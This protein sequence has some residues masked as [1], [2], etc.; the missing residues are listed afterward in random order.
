MTTVHGNATCTFGSINSQ[1]P[2]PTTTYGLHVNTAKTARCPGNATAW[3]LCYYTT[4]SK[5]IV[6]LGVYRPSSASSYSLVPGSS[7][8]YTVPS[9]LT[10]TSPIPPCI[11]TSIPLSQ[12]FV[13]QMGDVIAACLKSSTS[14]ERLN[15]VGTSA[16]S[17]TPQIQV[18]SANTCESLQSA[19]PRTITL[20]TQEG[21]SGSFSLMLQVSLSM[22]S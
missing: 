1:L 6:Y 8:N 19:L 16:P 4:G 21:F 7:M 2:S 20:S 18:F 17:G 22:S 10:Q 14:N 13:V 15:V 5:N 9:S 12:Q 11:Q 3:N